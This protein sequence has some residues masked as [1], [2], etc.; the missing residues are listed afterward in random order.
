MFEVSILDQS[1]LKNVLVIHKQIYGKLC[2]CVEGVIQKQ[3][4]RL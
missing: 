3:R 1:C 2:V 4:D